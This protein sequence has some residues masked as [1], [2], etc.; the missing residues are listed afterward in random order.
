M[1]IITI[2]NIVDMIYKAWTTQNFLWVTHTVCTNTS[3]PILTF[4]LDVIGITSH[5]IYRAVERAIFLNLTRACCWSAILPHGLVRKADPPSCIWFL[6]TN[7]AKSLLKSR[8]DRSGVSYRWKS[9][10]LQLLL[11]TAS[12]NW[13]ARLVPRTV[14]HVSSS[15][16]GNIRTPLLAS[17]TSLN[18]KWL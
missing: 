5:H 17:T 11:V 8:C 6:I 16:R 13:K 15:A 10:N 2:L 14:S 18:G 7:L 1:H 4:E 3:H 12:S 9:V